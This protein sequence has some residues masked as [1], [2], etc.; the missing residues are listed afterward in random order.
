MGWL[1]QILFF[2]PLLFLSWAPSAM[3]QSPLWWD[4]EN[5]HPWGPHSLL[6]KSAVALAWSG[7]GSVSRKGS[8]WRNPLH[9]RQLQW[10][11]HA[12]LQSGRCG[13]DAVRGCW[14]SSRYGEEDPRGWWDH[15]GAPRGVPA[16][17]EPSRVQRTLEW[18]VRKQ[19][20]CIVY[21][22][23]AVPTQGRG[24]WPGQGL[25]GEDGSSA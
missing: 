4:D 12:V 14:Y 21:V 3:P 9:G 24:P 18:G 23:P 13:R 2:P 7:G 11:P 15:A 22:L 6:H 8:Q 10:S 25:H 20:G 1:S 16:T 19:P 5:P 17:L